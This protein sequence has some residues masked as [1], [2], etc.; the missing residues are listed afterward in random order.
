MDINRAKEI[1]SILA[2]G[3][4]PLTGEV[5]PANHVCNQAEVVRAFYALLKK[6]TK[7]A[8]QPMKMR[9]SHGLLQT[10][11][12]CE[13]YLKREQS[14]VKCASTLVVP[15]VPL[16]P[17]LVDLALLSRT[18][19]GIIDYDVSQQ[20]SSDACFFLFSFS[21]TEK[22]GRWPKS[23]IYPQILHTFTPRTERGILLCLQRPK[24]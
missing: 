6:K 23:V 8:N 1:V 4:D 9:G 7:R 3:I 16:L 12:N 2:E 17:V 10:T 21:C 5:F 18:G 15:G 19:H 11:R 14:K 13:N 24:S 22:Q 20:V